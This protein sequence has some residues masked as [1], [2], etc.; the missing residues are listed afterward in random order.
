MGSV[1]THKHSLPL[2]R[3]QQSRCTKPTSKGHSSTRHG[4]HH[5]EIDSAA[6]EAFLRQYA[7]DIDETQPLHTNLDISQS[8][9]PP[10]PNNRTEDNGIEDDWEIPVSGYAPDQSTQRSRSSSPSLAASKAPVF[11]LISLIPPSALAPY[12]P[13]HDLGLELIDLYFLELPSAKLMFDQQTVVRRYK[14]S[15]LPTQILCS[16]FAIAAL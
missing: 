2:H 16:I 4:D 5:V 12:L 15:T 6:L 11:D 3:T 1:P 13:Q 9:E 8:S 10:I 7:T 14:D